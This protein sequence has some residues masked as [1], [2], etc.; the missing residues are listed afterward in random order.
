MKPKRIIS[1]IEGY[2]V[3]IHQFLA[4]SMN[5]DFC[6][7]FMEQE[8]YYEEFYINQIHY[9]GMGRYPSNINDLN[10][11]F[12]FELI[13]KFTSYEHIIY[14]LIERF[15]SRYKTKGRLKN[16]RSTYLKL[17]NLAEDL[18]V[19]NNID[20]VFFLDT[21]HQPLEYI[22]DLLAKSNN[23]G[24]IVH[25]EIPS[26]HLFRPNLHYCTLNYPLLDNRF[27]DKFT[28]TEFNT[29]LITLLSPEMKDLYNEFQYFLSD[30]NKK[31]IPSQSHYGNSLNFKDLKWY[32]LLRKNNI[33]KWNL[34]LSKSLKFI[35]NKILINRF[36]KKRLT[37]FY[38]K[39]SVIA[40]LGKSYI[41]FPLHV[42]P[43]ATTN[44]SG[45][46]FQDQ[47]LAIKN[48]HSS[49]PKNVVLY[50]KEHP[51]YWKSDQI[52]GMHLVRSIREYKEI[53]NLS[54]VFFIDIN[55]NPY[56]LIMNSLGVVTITGTVAF[57]AFGFNKPAIVLG[58]YFYNQLSNAYHPMTLNELTSTMSN[59]VSNPI[60]YRE[61]FI[62]TLYSLDSM[63]KSLSSNNKDS[64][65]RSLIHMMMEVVENN[66]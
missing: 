32:F 46:L 53:F 49:L 17:L 58:N 57:E 19:S 39:N 34:V 11:S 12:N 55:S 66:D 20:Y 31:L 27:F 30:K 8:N 54:N 18:V 37:E 4:S 40:D 28:T 60:D 21:P 13:N 47:F 14:M 5:V 61:D 62:K 64:D 35:I 63:S 44:P 52:E 50:V 15:S 22:V 2:D 23:I 42:Q 45:G 29:T 25:R 43:E 10:E 48:I 59:I 33:K 38:S 65:K 41:Y 24:V 1:Y 6:L 16:I 51:S 56:D 26:L 36:H 3:S 7:Y 9:L